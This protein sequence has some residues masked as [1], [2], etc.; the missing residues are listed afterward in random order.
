MT[1]I[2]NKIC[3]KCLRRKPVSAFYKLARATSGCASACKE[4][5]KQYEQ[6]EQARLLDQQRHRRSKYGITV[7]EWDRLHQEQQNCCAICGVHE[8]RLKRQLDVDHDHDTGKIRGLLCNYCNKI[9]ER[10]IN[11]P[12][13]FKDSCVR[14]R[15]NKYLLKR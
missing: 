6:T 9:L 15:L 11:E 5:Q 1:T 7:E 3:S 8:S 13:W 2:R 14:E 10:H 4:C 12:K